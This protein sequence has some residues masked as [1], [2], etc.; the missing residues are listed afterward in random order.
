MDCTFDVRS[1]GGIGDGRTLATAAIEAAVTAAAAAVAGGSCGIDNGGAEVLVD[2]GSRYLTGAFSLATGV[3]LRLGAATTL[4]GSTNISDYP[5]RWWNW[6]PALVDTHNASHTGIVGGGAIDGQAPGPYWATG[7]DPSKSYFIPRTWEGMGPAPGCRGE[8]R[9]KLVRFTDCRHVRLE[10]ESWGRGAMLQLR[11]SPD[12]TMLFRRCTD[13]SLRRLNVTGDRR[14]PNNDGVDFESASDIVL[15]DSNIETGDDGIVFTSGFTN[16]QRFPYTP[17]APPPPCERAYVR[18][19]SIVSHSSAIKFEAIFAANHST[20][21]DLRF[22]NITARRSARGIGF[23]QRTGAGDIRNIT[24]RGLSLQTEYPTG[25]NWWGSGEPLWLTN[26]AESDAPSALGGTITDVSFE[27][28]DMVAENGVLL[29]GRTHA[30][31]PLRFRNVTLR[32]ARLANCSC[33]KGD[34]ARPPSGCR[35][36]RPSPE[37]QVVYGN[38]SGFTLEGR[39]T[40]IFQDVRVSFDT[41]RAAYWSGCVTQGAGW[42]AVWNGSTCTNG[43][44]D[45][46]RLE[47]RLRQPE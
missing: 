9:P 16:E 8:C 11:N 30:L 27:D 18:N 24:F 6:D 4:L 41:P 17:D 13:V 28:V 7:F 5:S 1:F 15:E 20:V 14:W 29:S 45:A 33:A 36:Y 44:S 31:G 39:G 40:A 34:P 10:G 35:D 38:T 23:Q 19:V 32:V 37:P 2:G 43:G 12:W 3:V 46:A 21:R 25:G 22:E 26:V 47:L 42:D